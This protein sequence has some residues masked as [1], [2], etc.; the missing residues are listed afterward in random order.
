MERIERMPVM[1]DLLRAPGPGLSRPTFFVY[2][3]IDR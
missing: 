3:V 2:V 1:G